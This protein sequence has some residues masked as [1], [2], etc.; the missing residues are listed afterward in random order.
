MLGI[1]FAG[2]FIRLAQ[3]APPVVVA[4]YRMAFAAI[5]MGVWQLARGRRVVWRGRGAGLAV[6]AGAFFGADHALWQTSI[7]LTTVATS[8]LLVNITPLHVGLYTRIVLRRPLHRR[9]VLGAG[10]GLLGCAV[11][12]GAP[13]GGADDLR[14]ALLALGASVFYA[15]YLLVIGEARRDLDT[16][17]AL[18]LVTCGA[19]VVLGITAALRGDAFQGFP[20]SAWAAMA[21]A[22]AVSQLGGVLG[23]V[24]SMRFLP[25]TLASVALLAQPI[26]AAGL[27]WTILGEPVG[28][29]QALGG[30]AVLAGIALASRA[31]LAPTHRAG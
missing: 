23:I 10:L 9:F 25:A 26:A 21:G 27:A 4:F 28:P 22:A 6:A 2:I 24:W 5:A 18:F 31:P 30:V 12:L 1:A 19:A 3:P 29:L 15:G 16:I 13:G 7:V 11:L 17:S 8:T 14:G 20:G